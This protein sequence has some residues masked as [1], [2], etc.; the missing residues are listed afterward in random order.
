MSS[1]A[2]NHG[3]IA[4]ELIGEHQAD[5]VVIE[6]LGPD[7]VGP[8]QAR[9]LRNQ[10]DSLDWAGF[11]RHLVIDF[12]NVLSFGSS[13]FGVIAGFVRQF[14]TIRVCNMRKSLRLGA[15]LIGLDERVEFVEAREAAVSGAMADARR[16][17]DDTVDY[18]FVPV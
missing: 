16:G 9:E 3:H 2:T 13:A 11:P 17:Q 1:V 5:V 6:L 18:P 7:V 12:R 4:S 10:L 14:S 15:A 8:R